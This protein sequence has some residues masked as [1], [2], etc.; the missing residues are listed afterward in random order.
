M[1]CNR[2]LAS[3]LGP[4]LKGKGEDWQRQWKLPADM[5][6]D[7][8]LA[9]ASLF[10]VSTLVM[11]LE[12]SIASSCAWMQPLQLCKLLVMLRKA[13]QLWLPCSGDAKVVFARSSW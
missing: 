3:I 13:V 5:A 1:H 7:L 6:C 8:Y 12:G 9:L 11:P 2:A 4:V 10:K